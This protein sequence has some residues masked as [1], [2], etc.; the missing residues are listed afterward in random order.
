MNFVPYPRDTVNKKITNTARFAAE[1]TMQKLM[2]ITNVISKLRAIFI[3]P[4]R[5]GQQGRCPEAFIFKKVK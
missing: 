5:T 2:S 3:I 4:F 1:I